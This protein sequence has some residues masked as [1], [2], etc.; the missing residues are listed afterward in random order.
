VTHRRTGSIIEVRALQALARAAIGD[1]P[2]GLAALA[3]ALTLGAPEGYLRIFV[4]EG[5]PMATLFGKLL[6]TPAA[7][8][9][10]AGIQVPPAFLDRLLE[11][12]EQAGQAA[13]P[14][15]RRGTAMPGV[16]CGSLSCAPR[17]HRRRRGLE[18][19]L[20][21]PKGHEPMVTA[22]RRPHMVGDHQLRSAAPSAGVQVSRSQ[23]PKVLEPGLVGGL[24][25][26]WVAARAASRWVRISGMTC[27]VLSIRD[28]QP[29]SQ[30]A[31]RWPSS[32]RAAGLTVTLCPVTC[33]LT[34][35][36]TGQLRSVGDGRTYPAG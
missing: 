1:E 16:V 7:T 36:V 6:T 27:S 25:G 9:A 14:H 5:A 29:H 24:R 28:C 21:S 22:L 34:E 10:T 35:M 19:P 4:D 8:Q 15:A 32:A 30:P 31:W 33:S 26:G 18:R 2:G 23:R 11:A 20:H 3:E 13:L 12:F 17:R